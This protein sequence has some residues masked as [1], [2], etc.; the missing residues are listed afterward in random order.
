MKQESISWAPPARGQDRTTVVV[1]RYCVGQSA[2]WAEPRRPLAP[3]GEGQLVQRRRRRRQG[4][5]QV[6]V[7]REAGRPLPNTTIGLLLA[8]WLDTGR[9]HRRLWQPKERVR[10]VDDA[11]KPSSLAGSDVGRYRDGSPARRPVLCN[12]ATKNKKKRSL[13]MDEW[14]P[15]AAGRPA[16][17]HPATQLARRRCPIAARRLVSFNTT[18]NEFADERVNRPASCAAPHTHAAAKQQRTSKDLA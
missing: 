13:T 18:R 5:G 2:K 12:K 8:D 9:C 6:G 10:D 16:A 7:T 3:V 15:S 14:L 4:G 1:L 11:R 17:D